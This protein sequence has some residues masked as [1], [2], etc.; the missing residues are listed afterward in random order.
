MRKNTHTKGKNWLKEVLRPYQPFLLL[1]CFLTALS[2]LFSLLF[3]YLMQY[4][5]NSA[6]E[7]NTGRLLTFSLTL[8]VVLFCRII[9]NTLN[10]YL[11]ERGRAKI[12]VGLRSKIFS[13]ILRAD[14]SKIEKYHSGDLLNRL[15][16]DVQE[17]AVDSIGLLPAVIGMAVQCLGAIIALL[18]I[19][20]LF[21]AIF[22]FAGIVF[23]G[24]SAFFR[25]YIK[26]YQK[27]LLEIDGTTR[28]FMQ[29]G[30]SSSLTVK[31]YAAEK[32]TSE[33][34]NILLKTYF[35]KR[36]KR[37]VLRSSMSGVFSL[38]SNFGLIFAVVWC[39]ID[40]LN[41]NNPDYGSVLSVVLL[42]NQL[43]HPL[44][45][46][47]SLFPVFYSRA[48]SGERL[49]EIDEIAEEGGQELSM[50]SM[51]YDDLQSF[52]LEKVTFGYDRDMIF[53][54]ASISLKRGEV[55][56]VTGASGSGKST[57]FRLLMCVYKQTSGKISL[58][59]NNKNEELSI[60]HRKLFAYVPQ[61]NFLFSGTIYEN[62]TFFSE[63]E[64]T[65][66]EIDNALEIACAQF[67]YDLPQG[68]QTELSERGGGLSEGQL[69]RLAVARALISN[70]PILLLDESTSALDADTEERLLK[71]IKNLKNKTCF[72]VTH[73][74]AALSISD[75]IVVVEDKKIKEL[76]A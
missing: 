72:I 12:V 8:I 63:K 34:T 71:N 1:L 26:K 33:K 23:G 57:L 47:S 17:I 58:L 18:S 16:T 25:N 7:K 75:R 44:T 39:S 27:E 35:Q 13:K 43:Q 74:P 52:E 32:R 37:N 70:R 2:T 29:E 24:I 15:T 19:D 50:Q 31:A 64:L 22:L 30:I 48:V 10:H 41:N 11:S 62:L 68:L 66:E 9:V 4:L 53:E 55:I 5:I 67:V 6:T 36:M 59:A 14:Y 51:S 38:L 69:Q 56:C 28:S 40:I 45:S 49:A 65:Q 3:A 54:N 60:A 76:N 73:R 21:T 42:L 61:G 46:F 20:P